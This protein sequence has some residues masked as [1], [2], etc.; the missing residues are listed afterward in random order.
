MSVATINDVA[1]IRGTIEFHLHGTWLATVYISGDDP[2][3]VQGPVTLQVGSTTL[4]G[5]TLIAEAD[6]GNQ[7][8][9][10][11]VG[12]KGGLEKDCPPKAYIGTTRGKLLE[13]ALA[14]GGEALSSTSDSSVTSSQINRWTRVQDLVGGSVR[15]IL[16]GSGASWRMLPNGRVWVGQE[17]WPEAPT[18]YTIA[19]EVP[20]EQRIELGL[21]EIF[22]LPGMMLEGQRLTSV[23]YVLDS[24]KLR[25]SA[26]YKP[27][28]SGEAQEL[29]RFVTNEM[30]HVD[31][32]RVYTAQVVGQNADG[33]LELKLT[34]PTI[35]NLSKVQM[36]FGIPGVTKAVVAPGILVHLIHENGDA[37]KP[38]VTSIAE[39]QALALHIG[40]PE[41]VLGIPAEGAPFAPKGDLVTQELAKIALTIAS[42]TSPAGP[43][44]S[45]NPYVPGNVLST[46]VKIV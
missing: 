44:T 15:R 31:L 35:P 21:E 42:L 6:Q 17:T 32:L 22:V 29:A 28:R 10:R 18:D 27:D 9:V 26:S 4:S 38:V 14:E 43:V 12:G 7:V 20:T 37:Q 45:P 39:G 13:D 40:A 33:T 34:D 30:G 8:S 46:T 23:K 1:I 36:R 19:S 2:S 24:V 41:I 25:A 5:T 11:V 16:D 3:L